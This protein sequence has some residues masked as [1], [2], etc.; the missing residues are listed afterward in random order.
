MP[1]LEREPAVHAIGTKARRPWAAVIFASRESAEVLGQTIA[2]ARIAALQR[3]DIDVLINGNRALAAQ[4]ASH[5]AGQPQDA[6]AA[7]VRI[8]SISVNDKANAWNQY[9]QRVWAG[10]EV[11]FFIDGYIRLNLDALTLLGDAVMARPEVLGGTGVPTRAL[12]ARIASEGGFYGN[13]VCLKGTVIAE[14][15]R[16]GIALPFGLYRVDS[17]MGAWVNFGLDP[18]TQGWNPNRIFAHPD[19]SWKKDAPRWWRFNDIR[20]QFKRRLRQSRGVL[21]NLAVRDLLSTRKQAPES[22]P[23]T[24]SALVLEWVARCPDEAASVLRWN[25][26]VRR[27]LEEIRQ[28]PLTPPTELLPELVSAASTPEPRVANA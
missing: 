10:E 17:L 1:E 8:W 22:L 25:P 14:L 4:V 6:G 11:A 12:H 18:K 5:L 19:A 27:A 2:A 9:V 13:F 7:R 20:A 21:E 24:A 23:A 16:R 15:R 26:L 3:A 28:I